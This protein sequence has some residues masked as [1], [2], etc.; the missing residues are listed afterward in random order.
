MLFIRCC[1]LKMKDTGT[2]IAKFDKVQLLQS[3]NMEVCGAEQ[4]D[5]SGNN[6][7]I[8]LKRFPKDVR[9]FYIPNTM[10]SSIQGEFL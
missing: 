2:R 3:Y 9:I 10:K 6:R 7:V 5:P 4:F 1:K 8:S